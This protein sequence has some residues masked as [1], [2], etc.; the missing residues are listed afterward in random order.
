MNYSSSKG[1]WMG[2]R[3]G[4]GHPRGRLSQMALPRTSSSSW[5]TSGPLS[6]PLGAGALAR[7]F[8]MICGLFW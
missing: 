5:L 7:L 2:A 3:P 1:I 8:G 6:Y 4:S